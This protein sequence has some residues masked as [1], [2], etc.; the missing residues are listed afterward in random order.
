MRAEVEE[1][2]GEEEGVE[3]LEGGKDGE[4]RDGWGRDAR[5]NFPLNMYKKIV[6]FEL[7]PLCII[8]F[9]KSCALPTALPPSLPSL[10]PLF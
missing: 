2:R 6:M 4:G 1:E 3:G 7:Y 10:A 9:A 5:E 8:S